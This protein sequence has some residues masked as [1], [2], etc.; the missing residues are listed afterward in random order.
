MMQKMPYIK[1]LFK[2]HKPSAYL[3]GINHIMFAP[4]RLISINI[5]LIPVKI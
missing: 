4:N 2:K 5:L 1:Y 3:T